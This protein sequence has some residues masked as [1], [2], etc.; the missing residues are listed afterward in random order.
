MENKIKELIEKY[1][2]TVRFSESKWHE[3]SANAVVTETR[4]DLQS[5]LKFKQENCCGK[6]IKMEEIR[7]FFIEVDSLLS[8]LVHR[9]GDYLEKIGE[10][11]IAIKLYEQAR[12]Y[13]EEKEE[14]GN[15]E[16]QTI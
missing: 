14:K 6:V 9:H 7:K 13:Y 10:K 4:E 16:D 8:L 11:D 1:T 3:Y 5:L 15:H 12:Q 2:I